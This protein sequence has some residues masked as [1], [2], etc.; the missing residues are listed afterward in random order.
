MGD[1]KYKVAAN[2][3]VGGVLICGADPLM[4]SAYRDFVE[5]GLG[6]AN[7][8]VIS[9]PGLTRKFLSPLTVK[10]AAD[11]LDLVAESVRENGVGRVVCVVRK[12]DIDHLI[13]RH[14]VHVPRGVVVRGPCP[15]LPGGG[16]G[17]GRGVLK[18]RRLT[19]GSCG[20]RRY[21]HASF[22]RRSAV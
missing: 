3:S 9:V 2:G 15:S 6:V 12:D 5:K 18:A 11:L 13:V 7:P 22:R 21:D 17:R 10:F 4:Q 19:N 16:E 14:L 1:A 8:L 20:R